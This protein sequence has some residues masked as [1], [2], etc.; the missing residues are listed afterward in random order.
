MLDLAADHLLGKAPE[1][2]GS[3][4]TPVIKFLINLGYLEPGA[5]PI[6]ET[7]VNQQRVSLLCAAAQ[8][9]RLFMLPMPYAPGLIMMGGEVSPSVI[10]NNYSGLPL[11]S[12]SGSGTTLRKAFESCVGEGVEFLA[13]FEQDGDLVVP[14]PDA[15]LIDPFPTADVPFGFD[16]DGG[17]VKDR[18]LGTD[19]IVFVPAER[20][21][22]RVTSSRTPRFALGTGCGAGRSIEE[23][24]LHGLLELIERDASALWWRGGRAASAVPLEGEGVST[25]VEFL[26]QLYHRALIKTHLPISA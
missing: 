26:A 9:R 19:D 22:R 3:D 21:L 16:G 18:R 20:C 10:G 7:V 5:P 8:M 1:V 6:Q 4:L 25:A 15:D 17:F 14:E 11:G 24:A 13:Q 23:A 2:A 12:V